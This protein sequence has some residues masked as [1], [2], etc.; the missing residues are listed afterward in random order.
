MLIDWCSIIRFKG[1]SKNKIVIRVTESQSK[2]V[3]GHVA[4]GEYGKFIQTFGQEV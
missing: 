2:R 3:T 1:K 4:C